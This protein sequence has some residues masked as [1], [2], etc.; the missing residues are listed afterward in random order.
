MDRPLNFGSPWKE[1]PMEMPSVGLDQHG[2][3]STQ[4]RLSTVRRRAYWIDCASASTGTGRKLV[5]SST[6][7]QSHL[8]G[9]LTADISR[10]IF[11]INLTS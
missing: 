5:P 8:L 3:N 11:S 7:I 6:I 10:F 1:I 9:I 4:D 2:M